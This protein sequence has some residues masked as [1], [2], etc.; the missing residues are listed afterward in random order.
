MVSKAHKSE[1]LVR[2][3]RGLKPGREGGYPTPPDAGRER[4]HAAAEAG[5]FFLQSSCPRLRSSVFNLNPFSTAL[6]IWGQNTWNLN[7]NFRSWKWISVLNLNP[8]STALPIWG[9]NTWN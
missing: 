7:E 3:M 4:A 6:P 9:Q 5:H 1:S 2:A 8:F